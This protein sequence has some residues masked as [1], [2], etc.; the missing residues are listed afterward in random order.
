M[1]VHESQSRS[2]ENQIGR[3]RAFTG[4]LFERM[5]SVFGDF[6]V[7]DADAFDGAVN[8]VTPGYI[9][10]ESD[11]IQYNLHVLLRYDLE[12]ALVSG[13]LA[14]RD[15]EGAWNERFE[16]DFG[17]KVDKASNGCL[18]D[19]HWSAGLFG[20]FPTYSLGNVY[21]GCLMAALRN[22]LPDL[23]TSLAQGD[24][25][26]ATTWLASHLQQHGGLREP[27]DTIRHAIGGEPSEEPLLDY[28]E[29]KFERIYRL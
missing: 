6:G 27:V 1:G 12:R 4:H 17:V 3:S 11:E 7:A 8:R 14:A 26:P 25:S 22:D 9:R 13:D 19:V 23:D 21:A 20:Y 24:T 16:R 2:Y 15:L 29:A 5:K 18:Q 10:T 28:L